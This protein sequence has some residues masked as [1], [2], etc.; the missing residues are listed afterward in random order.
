M[1]IVECTTV[2][3]NSYILDIIL[4]LLIMQETWKFFSWECS[5]TDHTDR[6]VDQ[7]KLETQVWIW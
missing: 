6:L 7:Y 4:L 2:K 5:S 3:P 1:Y